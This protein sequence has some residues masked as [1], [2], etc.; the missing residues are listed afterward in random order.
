MLNYCNYRMN[1]EKKNE[2]N[3]VQPEKKTQNSKVMLN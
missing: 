1:Y 2:K 3:A